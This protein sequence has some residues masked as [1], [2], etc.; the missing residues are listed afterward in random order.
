MKIT[1]NPVLSPVSESNLSRNSPPVRWQKVAKDWRLGRP[2]ADLAGALAVGAL[3]TAVVRA[4]VEPHR[5][6]KHEL[7]S[8]PICGGDLGGVLVRVADRAA[9]GGILNRVENHADTR[10]GRARGV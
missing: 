2:V 7:A 9:G 8:K 1:P 4:R 5:S 6:V 3:R 10:T